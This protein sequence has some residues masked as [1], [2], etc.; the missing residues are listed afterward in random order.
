MADIC[1]RCGKPLTNDEKAIY[2]RLVNRGAQEFLCVPCLAAYFRC[3]VNVIE[4]KI[5][6]FKKTGCMLFR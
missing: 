4:E 2:R 5:T 3:P 6:Y 1:K